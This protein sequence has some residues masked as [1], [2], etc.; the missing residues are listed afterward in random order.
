MAGRDYLGPALP[1]LYGTS[2][3]IGLGPE[4]GMVLWRI[5]IGQVGTLRACGCGPAAAKSRGYG[6][7]GAVMSRLPLSKRL[8]GSPRARV[9]LLISFLG[10]FNKS[11]RRE[12]F[13]R[14]LSQKRPR[15]SS[16]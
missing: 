14:L 16:N 5:A 1:L 7:S 9:A 2:R 4:P 6:L 11:W 10:R 3:S 15:A 13:L 12:E 8:R